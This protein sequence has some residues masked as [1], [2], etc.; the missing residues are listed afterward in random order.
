MPALD[1]KIRQFLRIDAESDDESLLL[2]IIDAAKEYL[3]NA[4]VT[5]PT[6]TSSLYDIAVTLYVNTIWNG[7]D[8]D[9]ELKKSLTG[10]IIQLKD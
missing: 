3:V 4:G 5:E 1:I 2:S 8:E 6:E 10:M 7:G 9:A